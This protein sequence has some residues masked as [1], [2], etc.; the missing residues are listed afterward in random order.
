M[1]FPVN[2]ENNSIFGYLRSLKSDGSGIS[3]PLYNSD[4]N[5]GKS[6]ASH[7]RIKVNNDNVEDIHCTISVKKNGVVS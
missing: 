7:I 4:F 1:K 3:M 2:M 6:L 5:I